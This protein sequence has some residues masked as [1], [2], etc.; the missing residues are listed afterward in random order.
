MQLLGPVLRAKVACLFAV[1]FSCAGCTRGSVTNDRAM[2]D[3]PLGNDAADGLL[4]AFLP[5]PHDG[6]ER[7]GADMDTTR[8]GSF[9][10]K[11]TSHLSD[12]PVA[13]RGELI[14][15]SETRLFRACGVDEVWWFVLDRFENG[16]TIPGWNLA[17]Q[18]RG[19][20]CPP[21]QPG[22]GLTRV[23]LEGQAQVSQPGNFG[24]LGKYDRT[25]DFLR[26]DRA[27][28]DAPGDCPL[29]TRFP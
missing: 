17:E 24:H 23:Y 26:V 15:G 20:A 8:D 9:G 11:S 5:E 27:L 25:V 10:E 1:A 29:T 4:D 13:L 22:C 28:P 6:V 21:T 3:G 16:G 14:I 12:G 19:A 7:S 2:P 18:E